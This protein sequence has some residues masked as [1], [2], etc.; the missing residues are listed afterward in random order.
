M[1][2]HITG[3]FTGSTDIPI[4]AYYYTGVDSG[5]TNIAATVPV[6][7]GSTNVTLATGLPVLVVSA[8]PKNR[9]YGA[10]NPLL[11]YTITG[12]QGT[13]TIAV[14]SGGAGLSTAAATNSPVGTC[15][16]TITNINLSASNYS[17]AFSGGTMTGTGDFDSD[18]E[19]HEPVVRS[20]KPCVHGRL[21]RVR[22]WRLHQRA[23][24]QSVIDHSG[25]DEQPSGA[26]SIVTTNGTLTAANYSF[27]FVN[28]T[29]TV[30]KAT[31]TMAANNT[32][33]LY[34]ATD[35]VFTAAYSGFVNG[36]TTSVLGGSPS[37]TTA[38]VTNS[39]VGSYP[40]VT[41]NGTLTAA[42]YSFNFVNGPLTVNP[43]TLTV[44]AS[45]TNRLYGAT[46]PVFTAA[47]SGF[48]NGDTTNVLGGSPSL[49]TAAVT[50]SPVGPIPLLPPMGL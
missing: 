40:I 12:F 14:V 22:E 47:Y 4:K 44:E 8:D 20:D 5:V 36:D 37:L 16:I 11:T 32:N 34:G 33:R 41:T 43:A 1:T 50:N 27:N 42:N 15:P 21:Q 3:R 23:W 48:V 35:L 46:N 49:T 19:Q 17:F 24:R 7:S 13:D 29:L 28:G 39:P 18:G 25:G 31:L 10:T 9:L 6:F 38:A 45:S 30:S 26:I 2:G